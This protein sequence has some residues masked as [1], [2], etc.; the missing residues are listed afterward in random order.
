M[1]CPKCGTEFHG[2][3]C[4]QC[5][6]F[7][8]SE[9]KF[10]MNIDW[11][12]SGMDQL[13]RPPRVVR[14]RP[15]QLPQYQAPPVP[16]GAPIPPPSYQYPP[17]QYQPQQ[18]GPYYQAPPQYRQAPPYYPP[19]PAYAKPRKNHKDVVFGIFLA[20]IICV[21]IAILILLMPIFNVKETSIQR[22]ADKYNLSQELEDDFLQ[23]LDMIGLKENETDIIAVD[24][25]EEGTVLTFENENYPYDFEATSADGKTFSDVKYFNSELIEDGNSVAALGKVAVNDE[26]ID[27]M[28]VQTRVIVKQCLVSPASAKFPTS[29]YWDFLVDQS[30]YVIVGRSYVD[31]Q[32]SFGAMVRTDIKVRFEKSGG[33]LVM[34]SLELDGE[35]VL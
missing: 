9:D 8:D 29:T 2:N 22:V 12:K 19:R 28:I 23:K 21:A 18:Y 17:Q 6:Q 20:A 5:G 26:E 30:N 34:L 31:S 13:Q 10:Q 14:Q 11:S 1:K 33:E 15:P 4:P 7:V 27:D 32:N 35:P 24:R 3:F 16:P 25:T